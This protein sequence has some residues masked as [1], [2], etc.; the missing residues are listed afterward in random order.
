MYI[1]GTPTQRAS[2]PQPP[3][4]RKSYWLLLFVIVGFVKQVSAD[5]AA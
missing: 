1:P 2:C 5:I 3:H 4:N